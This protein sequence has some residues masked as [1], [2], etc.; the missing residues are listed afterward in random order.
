MS[1][2][3]RFVFTPE[4]DAKARAIIAKYP[5]GRQASAVLP[6][7]TL[8]QEQCG[9][10][11]P[12]PA[13]DGVGGVGRQLQERLG[14]SGQVGPRGGLPGLQLGRLHVYRLRVVGLDRPG[15]GR[16][17]GHVG[18][19]PAALVVRHRRAADAR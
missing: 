7:L 9:A 18:R 5:P 10:W 14:E 8:A 6:L 2:T 17:L 1:G 12:Q 15:E 4:N 11:L 3:E 13:L 19:H 16:Q